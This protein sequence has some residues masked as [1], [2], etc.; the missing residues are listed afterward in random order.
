MVTRGYGKVRMGERE[1]AGREALRRD[2]QSQDLTGPVSTKHFY[3]IFT[4]LGQRRRRWSNSVQ[5]LYKYFVFAGQGAD[6]TAPQSQ[7]GSLCLLVK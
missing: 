4:V 5:M 2:V 1:S 6:N 7:K 3:N